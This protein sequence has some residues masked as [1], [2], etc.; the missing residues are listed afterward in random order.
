[1]GKLI[2]KLHAV[3]Q[4]TGTG[5]GFGFL[6]N[7]APERKARPAAIFVAAPISDLAAIGAAVKNGADGILVLGWTTD[8][9]LAGLK[10]ALEG[11]D[12]IWGVE[13]GEDMAKRDGILKTA[14]EAGASFAQVDATAPARLLNQDIEKFDIVVS[15]TMPTDDMAL[16]TMGGQGLIP[17]Q[18]GLLRAD[19]TARQV[20]S[21]SIAEFARMR[22]VAASVRFALLATVHEPPAEGDVSTLVRSG[23]DGFVLTGPA[24]AAAT[25]GARVAALREALE[26]TPKPEEDRAATLLGGLMGGAGQPA[27][28]AQPAPEKPEEE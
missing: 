6:G 14:S 11:S 20:A 7:R 22:L 28:P 18:A 3:G 13:I 21:F 23:F 17:A 8:A 12:A 27:A 19:F 2:E 26:K 9:D 5:F 10:G 4:A 25:V 24:A 16:L 15:I 1:M